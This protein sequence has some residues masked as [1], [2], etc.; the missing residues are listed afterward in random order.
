MSKVDALLEEWDSRYNAKEGKA[1]LDR[2]QIRPG[3][4]KGSAS[5]ARSALAGLAKGAPQAVFKITGGGKSAGAISVHLQYISRHG[6][7]E[8]EDQDG[9]KHVG[10]GARRDILDRW[11]AGG[12]PTESN[13]KEA[14]NIVLSSPKGSN[15]AAVL[16]AARAFAREQF[17]GHDYVMA[18]HCPDSDPSKAKSENAHVH[19]AVRAR[20]YD[21]KKLNPRKADLF[22]YRQ[23]YARHMRMNG[24]DVVAVRREALFNTKNKG[25]PQPVYQMKKRGALG[26]KQ[27]QDLA[28]QRALNAEAKARELYTE[29]VAEL[30]KSQMP[31]DRSLA[32][33]LRQILPAQAPQTRAQ[34]PPGGRRR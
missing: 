14:F 29:V 33:A 31:D 21:G 20:G 23:A 4:R 19:L 27:T 28:A 3:K 18:L 10:K 22:S 12:L 17:S 6:K 1:K 7:L 2:E 30:A 9:Q 25:L 11:E 32:D 8:L 34:K 24:I 15:S 26:P 5:A 16:A 13:Y